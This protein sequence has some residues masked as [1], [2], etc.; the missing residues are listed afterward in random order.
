MGVVSWLALLV[1]RPGLTRLSLPYFMSDEAVDYVISAVTM[2]A[3][4]GWK[5]LPQVSVVHAMLL[6]D[7]TE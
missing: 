3:K 7:Q 1:C 4:H 6:D 5:L 2:I